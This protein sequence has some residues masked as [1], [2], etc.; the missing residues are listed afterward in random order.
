MR[1]LVR[2]K[3]LSYSGHFSPFSYRFLAAGRSCSGSPERNRSRTVMKM[4][5]SMDAYNAAYAP[6]RTGPYLAGEMA[7]VK[8]ANTRLVN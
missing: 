7:M 5:P 6:P 2:R 1:I 8:I 4:G 3:Y